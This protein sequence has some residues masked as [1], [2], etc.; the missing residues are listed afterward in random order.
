MKAECGPQLRKGRRQLLYHTKDLKWKV[1]QTLLIRK[2]PL[3]RKKSCRLSH[4]LLCF[5]KQT[6]YCNN[7]KRRHLRSPLNQ[8][9]Q[10]KDRSHCDLNYTILA[11]KSKYAA[12]LGRHL[13]SA[14]TFACI[15]Q[16]LQCWEVGSIHS[17]KLP[18]T[19]LGSDLLSLSLH[20]RSRMPHRTDRFRQSSTYCL[21]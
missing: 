21:R 19:V 13:I 5:V 16:G 8:P 10:L 20:V 9:A 12:S 4:A 11:V 14:G 1:I 15:L 2:G 17:C 18:N 7:V 3:T 6:V